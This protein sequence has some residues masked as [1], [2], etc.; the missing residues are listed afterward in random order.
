M[1]VSVAIWK[2]I[3]IFHKKYMYGTLSCT[4]G[5]FVLSRDFSG[6][7]S[8]DSLRNVTFTKHAQGVQFCLLALFHL[9]NVNKGIEN[10]VMKCERSVQKR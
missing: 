10:L 2:D 1:E 3:L 4:M 5:T 9:Q 7:I 8:K 6:K